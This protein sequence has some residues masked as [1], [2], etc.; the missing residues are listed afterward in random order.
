M[1]SF[2]QTK[3][4]NPKS[5]KKRIGSR[6][7]VSRRVACIWSRS[8]RTLRQEAGIGLHTLAFRQMTKA[9]LWKQESHAGQEVIIRLD[10]WHEIR[11]VLSSGWTDRRAPCVVEACCCAPPACTG[12]AVRASWRVRASRPPPMQRFSPSGTVYYGQGSVPRLALVH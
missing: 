2:D 7:N 10:E 8:S 12:H 1:Q 11:I 3:G 5:K 4:K 9:P 6:H